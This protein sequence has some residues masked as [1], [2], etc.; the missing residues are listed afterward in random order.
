M[1]ER[2]TL[3]QKIGRGGMGVVWR[4]RDEDSGTIVALKLL[5]SAYSDDPEYVTRFERELELASRIHS[6]NVVE[7]LGFGVREGTPSL[8][9][10]YDT[11]H[12]GGPEWADRHS[13][14][15]LGHPSELERQLEQRSRLR[16][17]QRDQR[18]GRRA[19]Q[20]HQLHQGRPR[21][22]NV[23]VLPHLRLQCSRPL[24][25]DSLRVHDDTVMTP[26][27]KSGSIDRSHPA[28]G[29]TA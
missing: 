15:Q 24:C 5:H 2:F 10:H 12:P 11:D 13:N 7:V 3:L 28:S 26:W 9:L 16:D 4:A 6:P 29:R 20:Q 27:S 14:Q 25:L 19:F 22:R 23:H 1:T 17:G 21:K 8:R 18:P